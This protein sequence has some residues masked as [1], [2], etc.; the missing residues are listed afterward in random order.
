MI[1]RSVIG[2]G[3]GFMGPATIAFTQTLNPRPVMRRGRA[4]AKALGRAVNSVWALARTHSLTSGSGSG[5]GGSVLGCR[6]TFGM[7]VAYW[8]AGPHPVSSVMAQA[9]DMIPI[10]IAGIAGARLNIVAL[11][12]ASEPSPI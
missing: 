4:T 12:E 8:S 1:T 11:V 3:S 9:I 10:F 5:W 7:K 6:R 2:C